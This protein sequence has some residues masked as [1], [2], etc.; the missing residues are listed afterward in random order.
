MTDTDHLD[1]L[2]EDHEASGMA[3]DQITRAS[4]RERG[5]TL[6]AVCLGD[7]FDGLASWWHEGEKVFWLA[8]APPPGAP[9]CWRPK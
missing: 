3:H 8:P 1:A 9:A 7:T 5:L 2:I 6:E 4:A